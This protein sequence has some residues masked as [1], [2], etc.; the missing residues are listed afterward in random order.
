[1][2]TNNLHSV[3]SH[4]LFDLLFFFDR[5]SAWR[6]PEIQGQLPSATFT[7]LRHAWADSDFEIISALLDDAS[8]IRARE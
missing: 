1:V 3:C 2:T 6:K 5:A 8:I 7:L 4:L